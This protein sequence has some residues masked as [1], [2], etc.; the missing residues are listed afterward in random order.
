MRTLSKR[1]DCEIDLYCFLQAASVSIALRYESQHDEMISESII[2]STDQRRRT[3]HSLTISTRHFVQI[4][5]TTNLMFHV[6]QVSSLV[7][8]ICA[9]ERPLYYMHD[10]RNKALRGVFCPSSSSLFLVYFRI[11]DTQNS[12]ACLVWLWQRRE[13]RRGMSRLLEQE[14]S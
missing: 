1:V 7:A 3:S 9:S 11:P 5:L 12:I 13:S 2:S 4:P 10:T 6:H 14:L 8:D